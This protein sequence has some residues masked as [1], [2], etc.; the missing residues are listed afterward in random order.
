MPIFVFSQSPELFSIPN[1]VERLVVKSIGKD[2]SDTNLC[3]YAKIAEN[4]SFTILSFYDYDC[5]NDSSNVVLKVLNRSIWYLNIANRAVL[6]KPQLEA[7]N[8]YFSTTSRPKFRV[9]YRWI[10]KRLGLIHVIRF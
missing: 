9:K 10:C 5:N 7:G 1:R 4:G 8:V 2:L 6:I 3:H